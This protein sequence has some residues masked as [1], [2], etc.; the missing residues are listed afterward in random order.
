MLLS[1]IVTFGVP[2]AEQDYV[3]LTMN[4]PQVT[5]STGPAT[6]KTSLTVNLLSIVEQPLIMSLQTH[7]Q[8]LSIQI[9]LN[10]FRLLLENAVNSLTPHSVVN[11]AIS[12]S[13]SVLEHDQNLDLTLSSSTESGVTFR[14]QPPLA[15]IQGAN[16]WLDKIISMENA[17]RFEFRLS[18]GLIK[19]LTQLLNRLPEDVT[20][21]LVVNQ[22]GNLQFKVNSVT[23]HNVQIGS[24]FW[25]VCP[26]IEHI[27]EESG[28]D[29]DIE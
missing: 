26:E 24:I 16:A 20:M 29:D 7:G 12:R 1:P 2:S 6:W 19:Q 25:T 10:Y 8:P 13:S 5:Y 28:R 14:A 22:Q 4:I 17:T 11:L 21:L 3:M 9:K 18:Y 15:S 27:P 23:T